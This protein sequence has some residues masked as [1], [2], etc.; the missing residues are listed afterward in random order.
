MKIGIDCRMWNETGM[1]RYTREIVKSLALLDQTNSYV[2]F[3]RSDVI[4]TI[5]L[6][7]NFK[8]VR[9]D[10]YWHTFKEQLLFPLILLKENLDLLHIP[11]PNCPVLYPKKFVVTIHDLTILRVKTGRATTLSYPLYLLKRIGF[12]INLINALYRSSKVFT[13]SDFVKQDIVKTYKI[14]PD[15][16]IIT[17]NAVDPKFKPASEQEVLNSMN[18]YKINSPYL[19]YIGNAHPHKNLERLIEVFGS[20]SQQHPD[21][22]LIL[23][24][25]KD[26][27]Y[28]RLAEEVKGKPFANKIN[29]I[30]FVDDVDLPSLY[31]G[32]AL[33]INPSMYEGFGIQ[34][35]EAFACGVMVVCSNTTSLPEIGK[36]I[37]VYFDPYSVEHMTSVILN[38][39]N[40]P[41]P[42]LIGKGKLEVQ[43]YSWQDTT[44]TI[45]KVYNSLA[46]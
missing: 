40:N 20:I 16:V 34:V 8:K 42:D 28:T 33:Y 35:L 18:K 39:I 44:S 31:T 41:R 10:I 24:G 6:P 25:K 27:F 32:A 21:Y 9:A 5:E 43:K 46:R 38:A 3:F 26:F 13:V 2:L 29:F 14:S 23:G 36:D 22:Q 45:L 17:K 37:A 12:R 7:L 15:K 4:D 19:F 1:G 11:T 30:G